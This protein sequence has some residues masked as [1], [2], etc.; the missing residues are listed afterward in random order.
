[1]NIPFVLIWT[2]S[3]FFFWFDDKN[4][5]CRGKRM[6]FSIRHT[7]D[8]YWVLI[9]KKKLISQVKTKVTN[10]IIANKQHVCGLNGG[11]LVCAQRSVCNAILNWNVSIR[12]D[13]TVDIFF[14]FFSFTAIVWL[15]HTQPHKQRKQMTVEHEARVHAAVTDATTF[16]FVSTRFVW[17]WWINL[18]ARIA[19]D[20]VPQQASPSLLC[21]LLL[22][23][24]FKNRNV[25]IESASTIGYWSRHIVATPLDGT[26]EIDYERK[27]RNRR[28]YISMWLL[29]L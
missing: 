12:S 1:M 27:Q 13:F 3:F 14:L 19:R 10:K 20:A 2:G 26:C 23:T 17:V 25:L 18:V 29:I 16:R 9:E 11:S 21:L 7:R 15:T 6:H 28:T 22:F 4:K 8:K 24:S 5:N